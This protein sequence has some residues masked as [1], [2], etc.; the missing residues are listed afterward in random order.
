MTGFHGAEVFSPAGHLRLL[1]EMAVEQHGVVG[2]T[3]SERRHLHQDDR[4]AAGKL[5]DLDGESDDGAFGAPRAD[6]FDRPIHVTVLAPVRVVQ[7]RH[8]GDLDVVVK[9]RNDLVAPHA[10]DV[11]GEVRHRRAPTSR[12]IARSASATIVF[13]SSAA[14]TNVSIAPTPCPHG[15]NSLRRVDLGAIGETEVVGAGLRRSHGLGG[16]RLQFL[17]M[18]IEV[19]GP[20]V[21]NDPAGL[22]RVRAADDGA[23][24]GRGEE[25]FLVTVDRT[26][27]GCGDETG[28]DP[29]AVGA[30]GQG[31]G[32]T[33]AVEQTAC[34][35]DGDLAAD[36][37]DDLRHQRDGGD[38]A[39]V[40]AGFGALGD[41]E[42]DAAG[43]GAERMADLAAHA[44]HED[45]LRVQQ[46][47]D[48]ARHAE[49]GDE[50]P[51]PTVDHRL[52]APLDL[53]GQRSQQVDAER[54]GGQCLHRG[55]LL[56]QFL[57]GHGRCPQRADASCLADRCHEPVNN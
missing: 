25:R 34:G 21:A 35:D 44:A 57:R 6:E 22:A 33:S 13:T 48:L 40:A 41:D 11:I 36:R 2:G 29:H 12:S 30:E 10:V 54:L 8:V 20:L 19:V 23:V 27:F 18:G 46:V 15:M 37:V 52:D 7:H 3:C 51:R 39:C 28:A 38:S 17:R 50:D 1:V 4:C 55:D 42:I 43:D 32:K 49:A 26:R 56:R 16:E 47:D 5:V 24:L 53:A 9:G 31:R 45:V 14:G